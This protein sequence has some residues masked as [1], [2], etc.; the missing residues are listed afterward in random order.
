MSQGDTFEY[1]Y[2]SGRQIK[3][4][5]VDVTAAGY[6][7]LHR[8]LAIAFSDIVDGE[9][10]QVIGR[11]SHILADGAH[12][13][14]FFRAHGWPRPPSALTRTDFDASFASI[15]ALPP[16][17]SADQAAALA[18]EWLQGLTYPPDEHDGSSYRGWRVFNQQFGIVGGHWDAVVAVRPMWIYLPN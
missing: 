18:W 5:L 8:A 17:A 10:R 9:G 4:F 7:H 1:G 13:L 15:A 12:Q 2:R 16:A 6:D 14:T 3:N 11:P